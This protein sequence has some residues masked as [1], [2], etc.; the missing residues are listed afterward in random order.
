MKMIQ[1]PPGRKKK[2]EEASKPE[3]PT[4]STE[5]LASIKSYEKPAETILESLSTSIEDGSIGTVIGIDGGG[6]HPAKMLSHMVGKLYEARHFRRPQESFL[7]VGQNDSGKYGTQSPEGAE[8]LKKAIDTLV[9]NIDPTKKVLIVDETLDSGASA[10][11]IVEPLILAGLQVE[12]VAFG[13]FYQKERFRIP[14]R[15]ARLTDK[16]QED[17]QKMR[18]QIEATSKKYG[19]GTKTVEEQQKLDAMLEPLLFHVVPLHVGTPGYEMA[20]L[21]L[22]ARRIPNAPYLP[23]HITGQA[24]EATTHMLNGL[25][26]DIV[27]R[28]ETKHAHEKTAP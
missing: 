26:D 2:E 28:Y 1:W 3:H 9:Q 17:V 5:T 13:S 23:P 20:R 4:L 24:E 12:I 18:D 19:Y 16:Q 10:T 14:K 27:A 7:A 15:G 8:R 25:G 11:L 22:S 6:R 21:P